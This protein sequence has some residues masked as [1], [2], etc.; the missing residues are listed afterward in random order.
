MYVNNVSICGGRRCLITAYVF[1]QPLWKISKKH[2]LILA[3]MSID[4][5]VKPAIIQISS[6]ERNTK[7]RRTTL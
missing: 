1:L 2:M 5:T 6:N 3:G 7:Q 4:I